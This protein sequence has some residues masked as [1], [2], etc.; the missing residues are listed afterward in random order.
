MLD[1][2]SSVTSLAGKELLLD[3]KAFDELDDLAE[4]DRGG[5]DG[6]F[7]LIGG[8]FRFWSPIERSPI[9]DLRLFRVMAFAFV[10]DLYCVWSRSRICWPVFSPVSM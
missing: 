1:C 7:A 8:G 9:D 5:K 10:L 3:A 4:D 2:E 6:I